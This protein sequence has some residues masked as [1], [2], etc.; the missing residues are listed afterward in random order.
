[1]NEGRIVSISGPLVIAK[2][3]SDARMYEIAR[4]GRNNLFGEIIELHKD[5]V[6]IQVYEETEGL[7]LVSQLFWTGEHSRSLG[8]V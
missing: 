2:G 3:L 8:Q 5:R 4:V 7:S 6:Y 1:V